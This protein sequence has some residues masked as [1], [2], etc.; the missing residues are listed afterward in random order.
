MWAGPCFAVGLV[1]DHGKADMHVRDIMAN[2]LEAAGAQ[3]PGVPITP[4]EGHSLLPVMRGGTRPAPV[5]GW[6]H[7]GNRALRQGRW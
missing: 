4:M 1:R 7:E 2:Y 6:E 5:L 3:H